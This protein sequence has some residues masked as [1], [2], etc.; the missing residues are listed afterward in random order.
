[1]TE[2]RFSR[3][4]PGPNHGT[5]RM[6]GERDRDLWML[7]IGDFAGLACSECISQVQQCQQ[8]RFISTGEHTES[9]E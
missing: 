8:R 7:Y 2:R 9:A 5:C 3:P 4:I 1:M 6:C